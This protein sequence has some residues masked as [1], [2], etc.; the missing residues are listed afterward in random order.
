ML[1]AAIRGGI[2]PLILSFGAAFAARGLDSQPNHD[3]NHFE[4]KNIFKW[5]KG[6]KP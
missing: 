5:G 6:N 1:A 3:I 2:E 4:W